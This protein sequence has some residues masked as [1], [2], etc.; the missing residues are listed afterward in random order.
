M[1]GA[2][3]APALPEISRNFSY[4]PNAEFLSK[5]I[6]TL[7]ALMTALLA[8][9]AG[10]FV[11]RSGRKK[12]LLFSLVLYAITG[13]TGAYL[14]DIYL[15]LAG[16]ALL[17]IAVGALMTSVVTLIGDY[18]DGIERSRF[19]GYQAAFAGLGGMT[20]ISVGGLLADINW[21]APFLI[22]AFSLVVLVFAALYITEP[23]KPNPGQSQPAGGKIKFH[24]LPRM[25]FW[26]YLVAFFSMAVF[27]MIPV[28]MPF[29][30]SKME[31]ISNTQ[32]GLAIAFMNI[33]SVTTALNYGKVKQRLSYA[34]VMAIVYI[35]V[36]VGYMIISVSTSY[37]MMVAGI[38][39]AGAGF[40]MQMANI[41]LWVVSLAPIKLRGRLVGY[42]NA[43]IFLGMFLSP[44]FLQPLVKITSLY[45]SFMIVGL[46]L[47][48]LAGLFCYGAC[49]R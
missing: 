37:W 3:I 43:I 8:P 44:V 41:N 1:A 31:G 26:V 25:V 30:L 12:V 18:F 49:R 48:L 28:Q 46:I 23:E 39:V 35:L 4:L 45:Q 15:I 32:V 10:I 29:M 27:Y 38:L 16:R 5:L 42:L 36:A 17:G 11:D 34:G 7:P 6:L 21:R 24:A 40:G 19:M 13:T 47:L 20:F 22:Y 2:I 14:S 9:V 33:S